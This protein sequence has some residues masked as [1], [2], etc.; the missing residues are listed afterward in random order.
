MIAGSRNKLDG[1]VIRIGTMGYLNED[2]IRT[3]LGHLEQ[4]SL[5]ELQN[6]R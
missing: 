3:D 5:K 6:A 4:Q 1:K 2:D